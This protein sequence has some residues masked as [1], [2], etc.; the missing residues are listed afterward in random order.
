VSLDSKDY[1]DVCTNTI[2]PDK[3]FY[4]KSS[5]TLEVNIYYFER[6]TS[7]TLALITVPNMNCLYYRVEDANK[8]LSWTQQIFKNDKLRV[9]Q[10][11]MQ[12]N[13]T[14]LGVGNT[15]IYKWQYCGNLTCSCGACSKDYIFQAGAMTN[16]QG[17]TTTAPYF[18]REVIYSQNVKGL[19]KQYSKW[20][21]NYLLFNDTNNGVFKEAYL[22]TSTVFGIRM[23]GTLW[24]DPTGSTLTCSVIQGLSNSVAYEAPK[25]KIAYQATPTP[26]VWM[27]ITN[28]NSVDRNV[29][30]MMSHKNSNVDPSQGYYQVEFYVWANWQAQKYSYSGM[31]TSLVGHPQY[32]TVV[33][34][35]APP[36]YSMV[37]SLTDTFK[38]YPNNNSAKIE[39]K[40]Y[41]N[42][43]N[44][45][46]NAT[47]DDYSK[48]RI[49]FMEDYG[50]SVS[51]QSAILKQPNYDLSLI[52][53]LTTKPSWMSNACLTPNGTHPPTSH[54]LEWNHFGSDQLD[55]PYEYCNGGRYDM[56]GGSTTATTGPNGQQRW[57]NAIHTAGGFEF[58]TNQSWQYGSRKNVILSYH[59]MKTKSE[60]YISSSM[61]DNTCND[62]ASYNNQ[63]TSFTNTRTRYLCP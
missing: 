55:W 16:D 44:I 26:H 9:E 57:E 58:A 32:Y 4:Q 39:L 13:D 27:F 2:T 25:C 63:I 47:G 48:L 49:N 40:I 46:N 45:Y 1:E 19:S 29:I 15:L 31:V 7:T 52:N 6:V 41:P 5:S 53:A 38:Y 61:E 3:I 22:T 20:E 37:G 28:F 18:D 43:R 12:V 30:I 8:K 60:V 35:S 36:M 54:F 34:R 11:A 42:N 51:I 23:T 59:A 10:F 24:F 14:K 62:I 33:Q 21:F 50:A 56:Y 17:R